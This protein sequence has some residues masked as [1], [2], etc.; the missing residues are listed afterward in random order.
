MK[1]Q[2][3]ILQIIVQNKMRSGGAIQMFHLARE[4]D[5]RGH[6]V[7][8]VYN[9][10]GRIEEDFRGFDRTGIDLR[11][12]GMSRVKFS[13]RSFEEIRSLRSI[14]TA[15]HYDIIHAHKGNAVDLSVLATLGLDIP[16]VTN[17]GVN[18]PLGFFQSLKYRTS[19][20]R[21]IIA[22]SHHVKDIMA[23]TGHIDT[24]K[25]SVVYGGVDTTA[26]SPGIASTIRREFSIPEN[27]TV[28]G[29]AGSALP[30]KGI[31]Y[32]LDAFS[33]L[34]RARGN[35][36]L[37]LAG[38]AESDMS[39]YL[40]PDDIRSRI[41]PL[42]FRTDVPNCMAAFDVFVFP[43]IQ[44]E[45]LTGTVREAAAMGLP[46]ITTDVAGNRELVTDRENG[47]V[48]PVKNANAIAAAVLTLLDNPET[49]RMYGAKAREF[50]ESRMSNDVR[51]DAIEKI[52]YDIVSS[53]RP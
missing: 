15:Q 42:G 13:R 8:A 53:R 9:A 46:I 21:R 20:I 40:V 41:Y 48:V 32:L 35:V 38:V 3:N 28:I 43:G 7:T 11:F 52:Y 22:V 6:T 39:N 31:Q 1:K 23:S 19:K 24:A 5:R 47:I 50:V 27:M 37:I 51:V 36:A 33:I 44:D 17:R 2:L 29:Y 12:L 49:A 45:G 25:I 26:F 30:R 18:V 34:C 16:I 10:N 14:I 4:L